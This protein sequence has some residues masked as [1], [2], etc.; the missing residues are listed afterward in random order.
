M[1]SFVAAA[2]CFALLTGCGAK[3]NAASQSAPLSQPS[4]EERAQGRA[5]VAQAIQGMTPK[6]RAAYFNAHPG[7]A[8]LLAP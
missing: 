3:P 2:L 6:Q 5:R 7:D 8:S 1:T 4:A